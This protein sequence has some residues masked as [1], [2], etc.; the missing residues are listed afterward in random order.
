MT[1]NSRINHAKKVVYSAVNLTKAGIT[2]DARLY[3]A[4]NGMVYIAEDVKMHVK[5]VNRTT[6]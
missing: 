2:R 5:S 3:S 1:D 4:L 6:S